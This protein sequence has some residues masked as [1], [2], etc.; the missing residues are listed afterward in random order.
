MRRDILTEFYRAFVALVLLT[1]L[2][3]VVYPLVV[4]VLSQAAF[5]RQANGSLVIR[6]RRAAGS[7]LIGQPFSGA[8]YFWG[9]PSATTPF[10]YNAGSSSGSNLGPTNPD[11]EKAVAERIKT[12]RSADPSLRT[13]VPADLVTSS[14]SGLDPDISPEA[15]EYQVSRVAHARGLSVEEVRRLVQEHVEARTWGILG[16]PRVNVL[17]LNLALDALSRKAR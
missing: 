4:T 14:A 5:P 8:K 7:E 13:P 11:L 10:P 6:D 17:Q 15:A 12:L 9:R 2:T 1:L 3:G 16:E